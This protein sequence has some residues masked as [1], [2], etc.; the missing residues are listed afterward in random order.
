MILVALSWCHTAIIKLH[1]TSKACVADFTNLLQNLFISLTCTLPNLIHEMRYRRQ[2]SYLGAF[3]WSDHKIAWRDK[4][5]L[6]LTLYVNFM[7]ERVVLEGYIYC[8]SRHRGFLPN[9]GVSV[10]SLFASL[11]DYSQIKSLYLTHNT[12]DLTSNTTRVVQ[13]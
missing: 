3:R 12:C 13:Q 6:V 1:P 2:P 5:N 4:T 11:P 10:L 8:G 9:A 7:M